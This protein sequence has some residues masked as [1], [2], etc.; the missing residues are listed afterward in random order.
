M[1]DLVQD[2]INN[3]IVRVV[4]ENEDHQW[5]QCSQRIFQSIAVVID[6]SDVRISGDWRISQKARVALACAQKALLDAKLRNQ[7]ATKITES[8]DKT[9]V[10]QNAS[11]PSNAIRQRVESALDS[12]IRDCRVKES[13]GIA[14]APTV[15]LTGVTLTTGCARQK[16][17]DLGEECM[18]AAAKGSDPNNACGQ[19]IDCLTKRA[20]LDIVADFGY[21]DACAAMEELAVDIT[22]DAIVAANAP[23]VKNSKTKSDT[24]IWLQYILPICAGFLVFTLLIVI[25]VRSKQRSAPSYLPYSTVGTDAYWPNARRLSVYPM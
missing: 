3:A 15:R 2:A 22:R 21:S 10:E 6:D 8:I 1:F 4:D 19:V 11:L 14:V 13:Q 17:D 16:F 7:L 25:I 12:A 9:L 5:A 20:N 18:D 24:D 23:V